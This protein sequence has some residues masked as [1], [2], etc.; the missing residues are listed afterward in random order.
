MTLIDLVVVA[1]PESCGKEIC[2][3]PRHEVET[4]DTVVTTFGEGTVKETLF[5]YSEDE[6]FQFFA[7]NQKIR[8]VLFKPIKYDD[9]T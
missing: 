4:G 8:P 1:Y 9:D 3:A 6:V 7:R 2:Y 5:T